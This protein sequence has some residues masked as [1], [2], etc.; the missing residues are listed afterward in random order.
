MVNVPKR[1]RYRTSKRTS[2]PITDA[3]VK[4]IWELL[5]STDLMQHEIASIVGVN[6]GRVSEVNTGRR[7]NHIT[8]LPHA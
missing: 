4:R 2:Q 7:G 1:P 3:T 8:G 5:Q 6:Q